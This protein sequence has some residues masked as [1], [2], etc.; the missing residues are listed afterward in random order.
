MGDIA[1]AK[2]AYRTPGPERVQDRYRIVRLLE[3]AA[4]SAHTRNALCK[5]TSLVDVVET[6]MYP[7]ISTS[8]GTVPPSP[9][10]H[11]SQQLLKGV[12]ALIT[13]LVDNSMPLSTSSSSFV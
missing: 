4:L 3:E 8:G 13:S 1:K 11:T 5:R 2:Q 6:L 12:L 7:C 9:H 10:P